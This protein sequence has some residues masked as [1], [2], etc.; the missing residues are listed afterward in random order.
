MRRFDELKVWQRSHALTLE[1]YQQTHRLPS[2]ELYG[3]TSQIRRAAVSVVANLAEGCKRWSSADFARHVSIAE[4][5]ASEVDSLVL[6][7]KDLG[8]LEKA[9]ADKLRKELEEIMKMLRGLHTKLM[10]QAPSR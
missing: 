6:L 2:H 1:L 8:Y 4:G 5:S 7:A 9:V 10:E 3:I